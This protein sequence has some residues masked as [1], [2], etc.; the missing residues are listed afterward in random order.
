VLPGQPALLRVVR[1]QLLVITTSCLL[2]LWDTATLHAVHA[3]ISLEPLMVAKGNG[4][5]VDVTLRDDG[6][7]LVTMN[8]SESRVAALRQAP[9][10]CRRRRV[11]VVCMC[12]HEHACVATSIHV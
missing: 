9:C 1:S 3:G 10:M 6:T 4:E 11:C 5:L 2:Y 8:C 7:P 12:S